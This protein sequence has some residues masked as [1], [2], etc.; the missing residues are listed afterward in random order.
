MN[1]KIL[2]ITL[3]YCALLCGCGKPKTIID[4]TITNS[5]GTLKETVNTNANVIKEQ[6]VGGIKLG[7]VN[8]I[9]TNYSAVLTVDATNT[10]DRDIKLEYFKVYLKD[11]N[12]KDILSNPNY[13]IVP[14][15][16]TIKV[17]ETM[18]LTSNI[19]RSL[20]SVFALTYEIVK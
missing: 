9:N 14:V 13:I 19:D 2:I 10:T 18:K 7:N 12:G 4:D 3:V 8:L 1:Y 16:G 5:D 17:G 6:T 20:Q 11:E 15:S